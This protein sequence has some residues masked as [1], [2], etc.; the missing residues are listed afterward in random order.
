MQLAVLQQLHIAGIQLTGALQ[1]RSQTG[2]CV[3][4]GLLEA[5]QSSMCIATAVAG[6]TLQLVAAIVVDVGAQFLGQSLPAPFVGLDVEPALLAGQ[7]AHQAGHLLVAPLCVALQL[8]QIA[9]D[10]LRSA[11]PMQAALQYLCVACQ[12]GGSLREAE[13]S[14]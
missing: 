7:A 3:Q 1:Q 10:A 14:K 4:L 9:V 5:A 8:P 2:A 13:V 12:I 11:V 6:Q